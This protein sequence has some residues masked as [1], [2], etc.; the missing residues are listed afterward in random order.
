MIRFRSLL[1][2][3]LLQHA[4][5]TQAE[6][7]ELGSP[8]SAHPLELEDSSG[9][10]MN[11]D[12]YSGKVLLVNFWASWCTPCVRELPG[13]NRLR[14]EVSNG[15]FEILGINVAEPA[16]RLKRF[17]RKNP[18]EFPVLY[19]RE[20]TAFEQWQVAVLPTSYLVDRNGDIRYR[21]TGAIEWDSPEIVGI[22]TGLIGEPVLQ[23]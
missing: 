15:S 4:S 14:K 12:Q 23:E 8:L 2:I 6:L 5:L 7:R 16:H 3:L 17:Y 10:L 21:A 1:F 18:I 13:L 11:L 19:D 9:K 22:I 20:S